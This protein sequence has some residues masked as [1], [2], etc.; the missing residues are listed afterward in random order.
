MAAYLKNSK[1]EDDRINEMV[2][3]LKKN[4]R[5]KQVLQKILDN[6]KEKM[7]ESKTSKTTI[8]SDI[9]ELNN[10]IDKLTKIVIKLSERLE[11]VYE[12]VDE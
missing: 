5:N 8:K 10:K 12:F 9:K 6:D 4:A 11:E 2:Y 3:A 1:K 7:K